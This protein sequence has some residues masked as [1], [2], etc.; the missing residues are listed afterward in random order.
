M[1]PRLP[2]RRTVSTASV[3]AP[4]GG[5]NA[6]DSVAD[7]PEGDAIIMT[8]WFP[9][10]T[11]I[12]IRKGYKNHVTGIPAAVET[13]AAYNGTSTKK[14]FAAASGSIYDVT[15]AGV[16]GAPVVTGMTNARWQYTQMG[17]AGGKFLLM[18][19]GVDKMRYFDGTAWSA[20]GGTFTVTG[21]NTQNI[22]NINIFKTRVW[23]TEKNSMTVWYLPTNAIAG[24]ALSFD[25]GPVFKMGGF[26]VGMYNWTLDNS[27]GL[28]DLG[29]FLSSEGEVA[30]YRGIDPASLSTWSLV[31]TFRV[32]RP[33]GRRPVCKVA[34]DLVIIGADGAF[35]LTKALIANRS[36][37]T[38]ALTDKIVDLI[39]ADVQSYSSNF[40]WEP[41]LYPIGNKLI[42]NVPQVENTKQYQYVMN[43]ITGA[44][45]IFTGWNAIC[46]EN[47]SDNLFFGTN[48]IV[49]QCDTGNADNNTMITAVVK[50]AFNYFKNRGQV[51]R[52]TMCRPI[53]ESSGALG[54]TTKLNVDFEDT[55]STTTP[56]LTTTPGSPWDLS[57]WALSMW[58][59]DAQ[60]T[61]N[62]IGV[63]GVGYCATLKISASVNGS[64]T[65]LQSIDYVFE[66]GGVI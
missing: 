49:C 24:A 45:C 64:N 22:I 38:L 21:V 65:S 36:D 66:K 32:G 7:M 14:L 61:K 6:K 8:N 26:L 35:A 50:P 10:P 4:V 59:L 9:T 31:G 52:F 15:T 1:I 39:T 51:K 12:E 56:T 42:I 13:V 60:V 18:V 17:T 48:G 62:W 40:G 58:S 44:W 27:D 28:E 55:L 2:M 23:F 20:D 63:T 29:V 53:F 46:F 5:L 34:S 37:P 54:V 43:T 11:K 33:I 47:F 25:L 16:V 3:K 30:V 19:N 57:P 41:V